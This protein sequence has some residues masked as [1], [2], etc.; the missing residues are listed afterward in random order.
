MVG[1][2]LTMQANNISLTAT[3]GTPES[4]IT[5]SAAFTMTEPVTAM[6]IHIPLTEHITLVEGSAVLVAERITDHA[7]SAA[8]VDNLLKVY[9]YSLSLQPLQGIEGELFSLRLLLGD[10]PAVYTLTPTAMMSNASG[11][12]V[13]C[14]AT[15]TQLTL[16]APKI[17]IV[18]EQIDFERVPIRSTYTKTITLRNVGTTDLSITDLVPDTAVL[19]V[20]P[21][22]ATIAAGS[23][24]NF[25]LTYAPTVRGTLAKR[26]TVLSDA[27]NNARQYVHVQATPFSVNELRVPSLSGISD[28]IV[29]VSLRM[30]NMEPIVAAQVSFKMPAQLEYVAGSA[31]VTARGVNH[32][33]IANMSGDTLTLIAYS[34]DNQ[35][36]TSDDG[37]VVSFDVRLNGKSGYYYLKPLN[38]VLGNITEENMTSA[39]YQGY[40]RIQSPT[41]SSSASLAFG[42]KPITEPITATYNVSNT[43]AVPLTIE[44]AAFLA[45]GYAV[46]TPLPLVIAGNQSSSITVQYTPA[47]EG[48]FATTMQLYTNDPTTRMKS[49]ALSG[50]VFEPNTLSLTATTEPNGDVILAVGMENYSDVVALQFDVHSTATLTSLPYEATARLSAHTV[51]VTAMGDYYRV[52][53]FSMSN[54]VVADHTGDVLALRFSANTETHN[55]I[56]IDNI[57]VT[58]TDGVNKYSGSAVQAEVVYGIP[59]YFT[60]TYIVDGDTISTESV[61][62]G[63]PLVA[64]P[65]P[66][67]EGYTF[68][69]WSD[70]PEIM[71]AHDVTVVG[72][73]T[74]NVE[75]AIEATLHPTTSTH[76]VYKNGTIYILHN[77]EKYTIDGRKVE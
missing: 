23:S 6:E 31:A 56:T 46:T 73:F 5:L 58:E 74:K 33:C 26:I 76:K 12:A 7:I 70:I 72:S 62:C 57:V 44:K 27:V 24:Q 50:T 61:A 35:A 39:T 4:E 11:A 40:V 47:S 43:G 21:T 22:T 42:T 53:V 36:F 60:L 54:A 52:I 16:Q 55:T 37:D 3:S 13:A 38:V 20:S 65:A 69:G 63:T 29:T 32:S 51:S 77:G 28:S 64:K 34:P 17:E 10:E 2:V 19:S 67:K 1:F 8:V 15:S 14:T 48:N 45:E 75:T 71:P 9:I 49:V 59:Q 66:T 25:T 68:S 30:N 41:I 18:T